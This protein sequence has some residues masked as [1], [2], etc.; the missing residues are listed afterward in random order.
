MAIGKPSGSAAAAAVAI[1]DADADHGRAAGHLPPWGVPKN[2][3]FSRFPPQAIFGNTRTPVPTTYVH[4]SYN[5][6]KAAS[7]TYDSFYGEL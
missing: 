1:A 5:F 7:V 3:F 6:T 2:K 4:G